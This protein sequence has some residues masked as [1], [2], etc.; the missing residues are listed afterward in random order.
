MKRYEIYYARLD[1]VEGERDWKDSALRHCEPRRFEL[2]LAD[3]GGLPADVET[4]PS[5]AVPF[6]SDLRRET[7]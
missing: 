2:R 5:L 6:A 4:T 1:P 7:G 3:A